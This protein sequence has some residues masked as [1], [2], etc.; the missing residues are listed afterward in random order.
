VRE[1]EIGHD[2][3]GGADF[4][5]IIEVVDVRRIEIDGL[6]DAA[7]TERIGEELIVAACAGRLDV[8]WCRPLI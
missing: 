5:A 4:I 3:A 1:W 7:Q 2:R 6:L 8:T